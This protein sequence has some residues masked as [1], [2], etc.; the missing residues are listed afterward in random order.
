MTAKHT[1]GAL[2]GARVL[3]VDDDVDVLRLIQILL[4]NAKAIVE[5]AP[6]MTA[7]LELLESFTPDVIVSDIE[8]PGH[9]GYELI[10]SVRERSAERGGKLPAIALS[11]HVSEQD[12]LKAIAAGFNV[13]VK[14]PMRASHL[15]EA[16]RRVLEHE[17]PPTA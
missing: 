5:T 4:Q 12:R 3:V 2:E 1:T 7:A 13:H 14:K 10:T 15:I 9:D 17:P 11:A 8:M 16:I 6:S